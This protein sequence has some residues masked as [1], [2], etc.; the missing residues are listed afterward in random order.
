[1]MATNPK[2]PDY[3]DISPRN[4]SGSAKVH[5]IRQSKF[6]WPIVGL[7][8]GAALL[9]TIIAVLPRRPHVTKPESA[10]DIPRQPTDEQIQFTGVKMA[11]APA[12]DSVYLDTVL[13]NTGDTAITGVQ[14]NGQFMGSNGAVAGSSSGTVQD[15]SGGAST[16]DLAQTPIKPNQ[17][18]AVRIYFEHAPHGWNRQVP[19][20]TVINVTGTT[21]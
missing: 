5:L 21:P 15:M 6:P 4:S 17:S 20:L 16:G 2:F 12:G 10:A 19:E 18:R 11:P 3:P 7:I 14:V 13:H 8:V 9:L 1:M